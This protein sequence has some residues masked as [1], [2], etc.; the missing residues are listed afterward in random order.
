LQQ[1][2][3]VYPSGWHDKQRDVAQT[4]ENQRQVNG[5]SGSCGCT[6][7]RNWEDRSIAVM[8][9]MNIAANFAAGT[10]H[11]CLLQG[12]GKRRGG[13]KCRIPWQISSDRGFAP[14]SRP[15]EKLTGL[16]DGYLEGKQG[17][18][19]V[20]DMDLLK[21]GAICAMI[22]RLSKSSVLAEHYF[23]FYRVQAIWATRLFHSLAPFSFSAGSKPHGYSTTPFVASRKPAA[24][25][26]AV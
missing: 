12:R 15:G 2:L 19:A 16:F 24:L 5:M 18:A 11:Y 22:A 8:N 23:L 14:T 9:N 4:Y 6:Y 26:L 10:S 17:K 13:R 20:G 1:E 21:C 25:F 7:C 3:T